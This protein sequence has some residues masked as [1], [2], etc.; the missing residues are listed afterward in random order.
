MISC[1][2]YRPLF[3]SFVY[4][5]T[6]YLLIDLVLIEVAVC[7][8]YTYLSNSTSLYRMERHFCKAK[9]REIERKM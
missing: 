1:Q 3:I 2:M 4:A 8:M 9:S 5:F 6:F 7:A